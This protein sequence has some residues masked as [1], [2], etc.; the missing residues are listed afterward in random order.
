[1]YLFD[2]A[3]HRI[4]GDVEIRGAGGAIYIDVG[5]NK[6]GGKFLEKDRRGM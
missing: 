6:S 2:E 4:D 3:L 1:M 5:R